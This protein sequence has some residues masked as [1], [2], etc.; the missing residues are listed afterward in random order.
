MKKTDSR[1]G[2]LFDPLKP[3]Y[4]LDADDI[5]YQCRVMLENADK[6]VKKTQ[7]KL[8]ELSQEIQVITDQSKYEKLEEISEQLN[9]QLIDYQEHQQW[10]IDCLNQSIDLKTQEVI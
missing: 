8:R 10:C 5:L 6:N 1:K 2:E 4:H 9:K 3:T 7:D